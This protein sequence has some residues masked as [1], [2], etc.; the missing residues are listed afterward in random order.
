MNL[1]ADP[2]NSSRSSS[3]SARAAEAQ[4]P[5]PPVAGLPPETVAQ[6]LTSLASAGNAFSPVSI[7]TQT[8]QYWQGQFPP[9]DAIE[10]FEKVAP[11]SFDRIIAMAEKRN[12]AQI[13]Q[14][15]LALRYA[16]R[17]NVLGYWSGVGVGVFAMVC[18]LICAWMKEPW[19]AA[20]FLAVPVMGVSK[21]AIEASRQP[22]TVAPKSPETNIPTVHPPR[23]S[24]TPPTPP[25]S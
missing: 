2:N 7:A 14:S 5:A 10:R 20:A 4:T 23:K 18:A 6:I 12:E 22:K 24:P 13:E 25:A 3:E 16:H 8:Q 17:D 21:A 15:A 19:V 9:P 11:G 1:P